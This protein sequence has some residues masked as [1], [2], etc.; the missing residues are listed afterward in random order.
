MLRR[1]FKRWRM[2][3]RMKMRT[4]KE[5]FRGGIGVGNIGLGGTREV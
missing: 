2:M 3:M 1:G 5:A 4:K